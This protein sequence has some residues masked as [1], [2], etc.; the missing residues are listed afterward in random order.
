[1]T[2]PPHHLGQPARHGSD[3]TGTVSA[4]TDVNSIINTRMDTGWG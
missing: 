4:A 1:M 2:R 3:V